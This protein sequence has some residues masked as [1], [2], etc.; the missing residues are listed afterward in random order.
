MSA[1]LA[2]RCTIEGRLSRSP[3]VCCSNY[4]LGAIRR[5]LPASASASRGLSC[6][7]FMFVISNT[8]YPVA[9]VSLRYPDGNFHSLSRGWNDMWAANGGPFT[10]PITIQACSSCFP[11]TTQAGA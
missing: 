9:S 7:R 4:V 10:F 8:R 1:T 11:E 3:R 5:D 2:V 6:C